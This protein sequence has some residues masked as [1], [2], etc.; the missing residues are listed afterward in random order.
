MMDFLM[1]LAEITLTMSAVILLLLAL[2]PLLSRRYAAL[3]RYWAWLAVAVRLLIP[4][5]ISLLQ[6]PVRLSPPEDRV[7]LSMPAAEPHQASPVPAVPSA[8]PE[9][10][11][12]PAGRTDPAPAEGGARPAARSLALSDVL[13][14]L[15]LSGAAVPALWHGIGYLRFR[16]HVRRW[17]RPVTDPAAVDMLEALRAE[18]GI[19]AP[20]ELV[21]CPGVA[22]PMM[23]GLLRPTILLP[24]GGVDGEAL[25]FILRHE[26]T[27]F[28]RRDIGY[29]LL[30]LCAALVHWFNPLVWIMLRAA[31]GDME[32]ACDDDVV[33]GLSREQRGRYGQTIV[34]ALRQERKT[35][36]EAAE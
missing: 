33:K 5:N 16:D 7:V 15:W 4:V 23:T 1:T 6:A 30:L 34:D 2:G 10:A 17:G 8:P 21:E 12:T 36:K 24:A 32:R 29:K 19:A 14:W 13:P 20:G 35:R 22:G 9:P 11:T 26:L 18:L 27:H 3:W 28:R 31:E 25:W